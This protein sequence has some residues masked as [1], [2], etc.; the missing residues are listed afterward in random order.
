[1]RRVLLGSVVAAFGTG[2]GCV[3]GSGHEFSVGAGVHG[4]AC[5]LGLLCEVL[6][7]LVIRDGGWV[8]EAQLVVETLAFAL[9]RKDFFLDS[10]LRLNV[11]VAGEDIGSLEVNAQMVDIVGIAFKVCQKQAPARSSV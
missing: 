3:E 8:V 4:R 1:M 5:E 11:V 7:D 6:L 9:N 10:D 2:R